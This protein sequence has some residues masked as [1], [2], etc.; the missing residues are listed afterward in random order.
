[1]GSAEN[2]QKELTQKKKS[3]FLYKKLTDNKIAC[4]LDY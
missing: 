4:S 2:Q 3:K 1:M